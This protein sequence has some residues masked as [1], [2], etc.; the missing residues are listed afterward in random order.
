MGKKK[1]KPTWYRRI[2]DALLPPGVWSDRRKFLTKMVSGGLALTYGSALYEL[3][4]SSAPNVACVPAN[5]YLRRLP[6]NLSR[7]VR[8]YSCGSAQGTLSQF[9]S[10][11]PGRF[12]AAQRRRDAS[13]AASAYV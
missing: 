10:D 5:T 7:S 1:P 6:A 11:S 2:V 3:G 12:R 8:R 9:V 13:R 4:L